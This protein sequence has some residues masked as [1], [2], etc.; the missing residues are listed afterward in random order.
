MVKILARA[1]IAHMK[2]W[3]L[4]FGHFSLLNFFLAFLKACSLDNIYMICIKMVIL[5]K[6]GVIFNKILLTVPWE[7]PRLTCSQSN[8]QK[9]MS[10]REFLAFLRIFYW[11]VYSDRVK[12][13]IFS[14]SNL[15]IF[16]M[17]KV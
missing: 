9:K 13:I 15:C 7:N 12:L 6:K 2:I 17:K 4:E 5:N 16:T 8:F 1:F 3:S 11:H 14:E 10:E